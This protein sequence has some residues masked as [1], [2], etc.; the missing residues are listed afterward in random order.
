MS[1][2][3]GRRRRSDEIRC[4]T[5]SAGRSVPSLTYSIFSATRLD[6]TRHNRQK[7]LFDRHVVASRESAGRSSR[8][9]FAR[10][11]TDAERCGG[12]ASV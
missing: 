11:V 7:Q 6:V 4:C 1:S 10:D 9:I 2:E 8:R 5:A 3:P 12:G